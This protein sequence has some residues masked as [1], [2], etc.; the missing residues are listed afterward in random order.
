MACAVALSLAPARGDYL[1]MVGPVPLR[2]ASVAQPSWEAL[3][4]L[5]PLL[6]GE[7]AT[8]QVTDLPSLTQV[9]PPPA[10]PSPAASPTTAML[11]APMLS[12]GNQLLPPDW[13]SALYYAPSNGTNPVGQVLLPLRFIPPTPAPTP[14]SS[15]SYSTPKR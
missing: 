4:K 7:S 6:M 1:R 10:E 12:P 5:P 8:N 15:A 13:L 9:E 11:E 2:W 3:A 14:P